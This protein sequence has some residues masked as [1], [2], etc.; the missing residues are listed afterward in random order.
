MK[1]TTNVRAV[2]TRLNNLAEL[3]HDKASAWWGGYRQCVGHDDTRADECFRMHVHFLNKAWHLRDRS[4]AL[5]RPFA[6][7]FQEAV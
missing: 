3:S 4:W 2:V 6:Y 1:N 7:R 5:S